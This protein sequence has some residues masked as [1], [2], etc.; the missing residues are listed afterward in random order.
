MLF[1]LLLF[2]ATHL[3]I[4]VCLKKFLAFFFSHNIWGSKKQ[5]IVVTD[6]NLELFRQFF[7]L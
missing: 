1:E 5:V 4:S 7:R 2:N 6:K 3:K